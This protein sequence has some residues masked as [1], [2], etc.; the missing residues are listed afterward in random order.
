MEILKFKLSGKTAF[1]KIPEANSYVY[2][3][4]SNIHRIALLGILGSI[5]GLKGYNHQKKN[6]EFPEFYQLLKDIK[7]AIVPLKEEVSK[8]IQTFNNSVGYASQE[9]GG[10]LIVREQWL[11]E[12]AWDIY[13]LMEESKE[14]CL[15]LKEALCKYQFKYIPY[16]GKNDH[17]GD[18]TNVKILEGK[19]VENIKEIHS[20]F[21]KKIF[22]EYVVNGGM[23]SKRKKIFKNE[24]YLPIELEPIANQYILENIIFT[25][26]KVEVEN[27]ENLYEV[28]EKV[29]YFL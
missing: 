8:K 5:V 14:I 23:K 7:I 21:P 13:I 1:F 15:K 24:E 9:A 19:N 27:N 6:E 29:I 28:E 25:N 11:E 20:L 2:F 3:T 17:Y 26:S 16:L 22:K 18:I 12:P 4:Y 10:N